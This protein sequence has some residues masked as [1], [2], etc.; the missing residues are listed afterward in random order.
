MIPDAARPARHPATPDRQRSLALHIRRLD[1]LLPFGRVLAQKF[2]KGVAWPRYW[3]HREGL[4]ILVLEFGIADDL[5]HIGVDLLDDGSR[6]ARRSKQPERYAR[7]ESRNGRGAGRHV[8]ELRHPPL[9]A[10]S[11]HLQLSGAHGIQR[12]GWAHDHRVGVSA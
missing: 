5:L 12:H 9:A 2:G 11:E 4:K 1:D 6:R 3:L 10:E 7:L 8:G